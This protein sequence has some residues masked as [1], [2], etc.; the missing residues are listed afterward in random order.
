MHHE[1]LAQPYARTGPPASALLSPAHNVVCSHPAD[2]YSI[3][4]HHEPQAQP[5]SEPV[6]LTGLNPSCPR[7]AINPPESIAMVG[8]ML[9]DSVSS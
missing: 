1:H 5:T 2:I 7:L 9:A 3:K 6:A 8:C 4:M